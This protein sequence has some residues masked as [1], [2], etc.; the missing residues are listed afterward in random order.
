MDY[1]QEIENLKKEIFNVNMRLKT[2][3]K[4]KKKK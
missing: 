2:V 4:K 1:T 3:N